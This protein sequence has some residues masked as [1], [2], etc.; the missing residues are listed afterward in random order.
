[1]A[2]PAER[3]PSELATDDIRRQI[4]APADWLDAHA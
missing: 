4:N 2:I 1:M 3:P